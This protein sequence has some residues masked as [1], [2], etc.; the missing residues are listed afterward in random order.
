MKA[1]KHTPAVVGF[2][3]HG[4]GQPFLISRLMWLAIALVLRWVL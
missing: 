4:L 3:L 2:F 1:R